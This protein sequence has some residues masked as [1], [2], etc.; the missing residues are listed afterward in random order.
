MDSCGYF[1]GG[2]PPPRDNIYL[3][4]GCVDPFLSHN[5]FHHGSRPCY[6]GWNH[7]TEAPSPIK[8]TQPSRVH[9]IVPWWCLRGTVSLVWVSWCPCG[10]IYAISSTARFSIN[11]LRTVD[12][13]TVE[14]TA[15]L[16]APAVIHRP[17]STPRRLCFLFDARESSWQ[18]FISC[19]RPIRHLRRRCNR[20][21][22]SVEVTMALAASADCIRLGR[23]DPLFKMENNPSE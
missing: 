21:N 13:N 4:P 5:P 3:S 23:V 16:H 12:N 11:S 2:P 1:G 10:L 7:I 17:T 20:F 14:S 15:S 19:F 6:F 22:P 9:S 18:R 8:A